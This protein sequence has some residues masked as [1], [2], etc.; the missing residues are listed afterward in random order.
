M[1]QVDPRID[2]NEIEKLDLI[3]EFKFNMILIK[4]FDLTELAFLDIKK[5]L[6]SL[7]NSNVSLLSLEDVA[8][9][10]AKEC[11]N[12]GVLIDA[13]VEFERNFLDAALRLFTNSDTAVM[14]SDFQLKNQNEVECIQLPA[15]SPIRYESRDYLGSVLVFD[16]D[17]LQLSNKEELLRETIITQ[18]REMSMRIS[19]W[20]Q[21]TYTCE[22]FLDIQR[23]AVNLSDTSELISIIV[24]T[25]GI[26]DERNSL[27]E[28][29]VN[30]LTKQ[31][32]N[33]KIEVIVVADSGFDLNVI[34]RT[35][36]L[37]PNNWKF[38][39]IEFPEPF[40]FSK[41]CNIGAS[42]SSGDVLVF[43]NDDIE[44][45]SKDAIEKLAS[46][47]LL[48]DVGAVGSL[49][50]FAD[51]SI[52]HAGI[53]LR[54][55]KPRNSYLDQFPRSTI[56]GDLEVPHEVSAVTG[57]CLAISRKVFRSV[58]GWNESLYNSYNDVDLCLR[59]NQIGLQTIIRNEL[60]IVHH[61]S[62]SR[63]ASFDESSFA[64]LKSLWPNDLGN[65]M[66]L[67]SPIVLGVGYQGPWGVQKESRNYYS[68]RYLKYFFFLSK[69]VGMRRT[70]QA[71][72]RRVLGKSSALMK[73]N[74]KNYL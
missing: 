30:T 1:Q 6:Q 36:R 14:Y 49:L 67:R 17:K 19:R 48:K 53:T 26:A 69:Q 47:A 29:C 28:R 59:L 58:G 27:L 31:V 2:F 65:E 51:G 12:L 39:V 16:F 71:I 34:D 73:R 13:P 38:K 60:D 32:A 45:I 63:D 41:K 23:P 4:G 21:V 35:S 62:V 70:L 3:R 57:A 46:S 7:A 24:P 50:K 10:N 15:W 66:Y 9:D 64:K 11:R 25:R 44:L 40:N 37:L 22:S 68:G 61:E 52:Q 42:E 5:Q 54:E 33:S 43:L 74:D 72:Y 56:A 20:P 8:S 55:M 18:A